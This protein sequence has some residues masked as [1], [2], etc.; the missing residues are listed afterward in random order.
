MQVELLQIQKD[1][2]EERVMALD[3]EKMAPWVREY[4]INKQ[5]QIAAKSLSGEG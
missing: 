3:V 5:K 4:Y 1:E 2:H